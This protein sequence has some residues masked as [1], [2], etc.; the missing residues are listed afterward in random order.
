[1][2]K[3]KIFFSFL[4]F[5]FSIIGGLLFVQTVFAQEFGIN[6]VGAE[7]A[8]PTEDPRIVAAQIIRVA[9]GFLGILALAI[10]LYGGF[11]WMTAAGNEER[12]A[13]AKKI[14]T[15]A[16]IGL[17]IIIFAFGITQFVLNKLMEAAGVGVEVP[18]GPSGPPPG[19]PADAFLV[20]SISPSGSIPI[21]NVVVRVVFNRNVDLASLQAEGNFTVK[22]SADQSL[23]S[24]TI[25]ASGNLAEFTPTD[26][27]PPPNGGRQCFDADTE[28]VVEVT[29]AVRSADGKSLI[30]GGLAPACRGFF[31]TGDLVD[32]TGPQVEITYPDPG[33]SVSADAIVPVEAHA[34]DDAGIAYLEYLADGAFFG[35]D[36]P[37]GPTP[38]EFFSSADWDTTG[39]TLG[40]RHTLTSK[41]FDIDT[42]NTISS[43]VEVIVRAAH[44]FN[45]GDAPDVDETGVDCGGADCGGC[46]GDSCTT[47]ADCSGGHCEAGVCTNLPIITSVQPDNGAPGNYIT[48]FGHY[49]RTNPGKVIFLGSPD[50]AD[51]KVAALADCLTPWQDSQIVVKVPDEV[52][53]G[54]IRVEEGTTGNHYTDQTDDDRGPFLPNF[55]VNETMRP[56]LCSAEPVSGP[57]KTLVTLTGISF[58]ERQTGD[59]ITFGGTRAERIESWVNTSILATVPNIATATVSVQVTKAG[60]NS[61]PVNF[62]VTPVAEAPKI[63]R[64]EP[65]SGPVG[66]YVTI[67]G[68]NFG[69]TPGTVYFKDAEGKDIL[70]ATDFPEACST[71]WWKNDSVVV[72]VPVGAANGILKL[73]TSAGLTDDTSDLSPSRFEVTTGT[74]KPGICLLDPDNGPE[75]LQVNIYGERLGSSGAVKFWQNITAATTAWSDAQIT[76]S[77]PSGATTGPV[78]VTVGTATSN[79]LNF[80]VRDC[81]ILGCQAG[82]ECCRDGVCV[83]SPPTGPGCVLPAGQGYYFWQF[84]TGEIP[85]FPQVVEEC[86]GPPPPPQPSPSPTPWSERGQTSV[87]VNAKISAR[88]TTEIDLTTLTLGPLGNVLVYKCTGSD[89]DPCASIASSPVSGTLAKQNFGPTTN[90]ARVDFTPSGLLEQNTWYQITLKDGITSV[91]GFRLDGDKDGNEGGDYVFKF[92]TRNN[93][94]LCAV[95]WVGVQ[96]YLRTAQEEN[97]MIA[98][99]GDALA[100]GDFCLLLNSSTYPWDWSVVDPVGRGRLFATVYGGFTLDESG[101][102]IS[103]TPDQAVATAL[104][105]TIGTPLA[106]H[107]P[108]RVTGEIPAERKSGY[109]DLAIDFTDPK[110]VEKWPD[111]REACI[112][113]AVGARFNTRMNEASVE[114]RE[115]VKLFIWKCG[116]GV[117]EPGE[118]CDDGNATP[119]DGCSAICQNEGTTACTIPATQL[120][121]CGNGRRETGEDCDG[122]PFPGGCSATCLNTGT[123]TCGNGALE[124]GEDCDDGNTTS[125][126]GCSGVCL[127]EGTTGLVSIGINPFYS[128]SSR[129]YE[130]DFRPAANLISNT[131]YRALISGNV[132]SRSGVKLTD[133]NY[134][135]DKNGT[136]DSYSW[137]FK[138]KNDATPCSV[139]RVEVN[140]PEARLNFVGAKEDYVSNPFGAP[141]E[142]SPAGQQLRPLSYGWGWSSEYPEVAT[143][144]NDDKYPKCDNDVIEFGEDCDDGNLTSRD[145]CDVSCLNEGSTGSAVCG[146]G[147]IELGEDCDDGNNRSGDGCNSRCQHEGSIAGGSRCGNFAVE[148]GEDCDDGNTTSGDGCSNICL[149]EGTKLDV[150][151]LTDPFQ[152]AITHGLRTEDVNAGRTE[153]ATKIS[154]E[155]QGKSGSGNL[156]MVC[157]YGHDK[158]CLASTCRGGLCSGS[159]RTCASDA[160]CELGTGTDSCC[161]FKPKVE[162]C[163]PSTS[164]TVCSSGA[165]GVCRNAKISVNF[166][167]E[168]DLNSI[169]GNI[170]IAEKKAAEK[171]PAGSGTLTDVDGVW[172][173]GGGIAPLATSVRNVE[174]AKVIKTVADVYL[175][176]LLE[177]NRDYKVI[178]KG[179]E[180]ATLDASEGVKNKEGV[181]LGR[182]NYDFHDADGKIYK[183]YAWT[184]TTGSDICIL[185]KVVIDPSFYLFT[186]S[187]PPENQ[188]VFHADAQDWRSRSISPVS[189]VY[190]WSWVWASNIS[191]TAPENIVSITNTNSPTQTATAQ[192]RNGEEVL[193][194]TATITADTILT[195]STKDKTTTGHANVTVFICENPWPS[196]DDFY[197]NGGYADGTYNF[198]TYYCRDR[199]EFG[200]DDDLPAFGEPVI[201]NRLPTDAAKDELLREYFFFPQGNYCSLSFMPCSETLPCSAGAGECRQTPDAIGIRIYENADHLPL[202]EW[203]QTQGLAFG[204]PQSIEVDGY[205]AIRDGRTVYVMAANDTMGGSTLYTNVYLISYSDNANP[206]TIEIYNQLLTNLRF[207]INLVNSRLCLAETP[208]SCPICSARRDQVKLCAADLTKVCVADADCPEGKGPCNVL[209]NCSRDLDC[210]PATLPATIVCDAPKD[211]LVRDV[212]RILDLQNIAG[213]LENYKMTKGFYPK[214]EAGTYIRA[215][216]ASVWGSWA[217]VLGNE[218]QQA[219]P[220]DPVNKIVGC[221]GAGYEGYDSTTCWNVDSQTY[222]CPVGSHIYQYKFN[223]ALGTYKLQSD[224]EYSGDR[225]LWEKDLSNK[226][227]IQ[228][229]CQGTVMRNEG[230]C[231]DGVINGTEQ[232]EV[233]QTKDENCAIRT[234]DKSGTKFC[235]GK[236]TQGCTADA[237]CVGFGTCV[238]EITVVGDCPATTSPKTGTTPRPGRQAYE[239][240]P[241]TCLWRTVGGCSVLCGDGVMQGGE[242]CDQGPTGGR[243]PRGGTSGNNQYACTSTCTW[244]GGYCGDGTPQTAYGERCDDM[245]CTL[246][247]ACANSGGCSCSVTKGPNTLTCT[248]PNGQRTCGNGDYGIKPGTSPARSWCKL[249]CSGSGPY[250]GDE[251]VNGAETCDGGTESSKGSCSGAS[252]NIP[253]ESHNDCPAGHCSATTGQSC[254]NDGDC[255]SGETCSGVVTC[256]VCDPTREGYPQFKTRWCS[257][258]CVLSMW[259][260][261]AP[262]GVCGNGV[263]EGTEECDDGNTN[264]NDNCA[265]CKNARCGD[266]NVQ[267]GVEACDAGAQNGV[268][269]TARYGETCNYC[270]TTCTTVTFSGAFCGDKFKNGSEICD[271]RQG[272]ELTFGTFDGIKYFTDATGA[273]TSYRVPQGFDCPSGTSGT[274]PAQS[275]TGNLDW[276]RAMCAA[277]CRSTC[278]SSYNT[279]TLTFGPERRTSIELASEEIIPITLPACR[280]LGELRADVDLPEPIP[281]DVV[282]VTD[283]SGSMIGGSNYPGSKDLTCLD[284]TGRT[285]TGQSRMDCARY[286]LNSAVGQLFDNYENVKIGLVSFSNYTTAQKDSDLLSVASRSI[287]SSAI[288]GYTNGTLLGS[289]DIRAGLEM[290]T[291][292]LTA[293]GVL[294]KKIIILMSDGTATLPTPDPR[295][296]ASVAANN[297]KAAEIEIYTIVFYGDQAAKDD[298][299][300]WSSDP[301]THYYEATATLS[302]VY[303]RIIDAIT[304]TITIDETSTAGVR[305]GIQ[306]PLETDLSC[307]STARPVNFKIKFSGEGKATISNLKAYI[308]PGPPW[309]PSD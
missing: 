44:C 12:L 70:A 49:F 140:P 32:V 74:P 290:A 279:Q 117:V 18:T 38:R 139:D 202:A 108:V 110:V 43:G 277:D 166:D 80:T 92:K 204:A 130:L 197:A 187:T 303:Q 176:K 137:A 40:S 241:A 100:A 233:G 296:A 85:V 72:K 181:V 225:T 284:E 7:I 57:F 61:N 221:T 52:A 146:N 16:A 239:C 285:R 102:K 159:D 58:G 123:A 235:S 249:D 34:T 94:D 134:D 154:A 26:S 77:V 270:S 24:G 211:K 157:G 289:T 95:G 218:L 81:R 107:P 145:G 67:F 118:D 196:I 248:V 243:V 229:T 205:P 209:V 20:R 250:C 144:T 170:I 122:V 175:T 174:I 2:S 112:N 287:L 213:L 306:V 201:N 153:S 96:P 160:D 48:I 126:D 171:C 245:L 172:C 219:L 53:D 114:S 173:F 178:V 128:E 83:L 266:G 46:E 151:T 283:R 251:I 281:L 93:L 113:A 272:T 252:W 106:E 308:C 127:N 142:C 124:E 4:L 89:P 90:Q 185:E 260:P 259:G 295:G 228:N 208:P 56:G 309:P 109:G 244:T 15:S 192:N 76:T 256:D 179:D 3:R 180:E 82:Q 188:N 78:N 240:N 97:E 286:A 164:V 141:D 6:A 231:G 307:Q 51:D 79:S 177:P 86:T 297:A 19:L 28:F 294:G 182:T 103:S 226:F 237:D 195:P 190:A 282:F 133:L 155:T 273:S 169:T 271:D 207:N 291:G 255:P 275:A 131:W 194:A 59:D 293:P 276:N 148:N 99:Q 8:L 257:D 66:E 215:L 60:E 115:N 98:Y 152:T 120:N 125:G 104:L 116:N 88:F 71:N 42:N 253:C 10:I 298:M 183:S 121:C 198:K 242:Q 147:R 232:C 220:I 302:D 216:T 299:K 158:P 230:V 301:S 300:N 129:R 132:E 305:E 254:R 5:L 264:N 268:A 186:K 222:R 22:K 73:T 47:D 150:P 105:E 236:V 45:D 36:A 162:T 263:K 200:T 280:V 135:I 25:T 227:E 199:G 292:V 223:P 212:G 168:M 274:C 31:T 163:D 288:N 191:D 23:V 234:C 267:T 62:T 69:D 262:T 87:C 68:S 269:C 13:K 17:L 138:T 136:V 278:P 165:T 39:I 143:V 35:T 50:A 54:P 210:P 63:L 238:Q 65:T 75:N 203:Y 14:L 156:T 21:R 161:H 206:D 258:R 189:G 55:D 214:L 167:Q 265:A 64:F 119:R 304:T 9:L 261:C 247:S 29:T 33:Q 37:T 101:N 217:G 224:F 84:S 1:M 41:A 111:C 246:P 149:N 30:C 193:S 27:C 91:D 11:I 184:F